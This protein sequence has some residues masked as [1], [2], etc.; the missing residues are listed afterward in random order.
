[1]AYEK[2]LLLLQTENNESSIYDYIIISNANAIK[3]GSAVI[4]W[5]KESKDKN[6]VEK[7]KFKFVTEKQITYAS[8]I[9][10]AIDLL[11]E[12]IIPE[13]SFNVIYNE[14]VILKIYYIDYTYIIEDK[15][16][17]VGKLNSIKETK[18]FIKEK[19]VEYYKFIT[20]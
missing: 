18:L 6:S 8:N 12:S 11:L 2:E 7:W 10:C 20:K 19:I 5:N 16:D 13:H 4:I 1:M 15:D 9:S 17:N 3:N 14:E